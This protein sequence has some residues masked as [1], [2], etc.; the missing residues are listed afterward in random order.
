MLA[1]LAQARSAVAVTYPAARIPTAVTVKAKYDSI[2]N[3]DYSDVVLLSELFLD[4][5]YLFCHLLIEFV[6]DAPDKARCSPLIH[7]A[8]WPDLNAFL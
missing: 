4:F 2:I 6:F 3:L 5:L 8:S 7:I 1:R